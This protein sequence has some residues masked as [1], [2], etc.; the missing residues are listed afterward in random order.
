MEFI[1]LAC[2]F[3][4]GEALANYLLHGGDEALRICGFSLVVS[5]T[6]FVKIAEQVE[7]FDV[8]I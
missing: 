7:W 5:E 3:I 6:L 8:N 1:G 4:E 2:E